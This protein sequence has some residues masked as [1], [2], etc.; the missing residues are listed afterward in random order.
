MLPAVALFINNIINIKY[1]QCV[2]RNRKQ[3]LIWKTSLFFINMDSMD[4]N[5]NLKNY[6]QLWH[7]T[8]LN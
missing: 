3:P 1:A 5:Q 2:V 8:F 4:I 6:L 7:T